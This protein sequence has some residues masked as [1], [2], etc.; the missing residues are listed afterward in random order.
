M[1]S[2]WGLDLSNLILQTRNKD[3]VKSISNSQKYFWFKVKLDDTRYS[4][5]LGDQGRSD[6]WAW[7]VRD[8]DGKQV[9]HNVDIK[10]DYRSTIQPLQ[11]GVED[12]KPWLLFSDSRNRRIEIRFN[13]IDNSDPM[14]TL[15]EVTPVKIK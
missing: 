4:Y 13:S 1:T 5:L 6:P 12:T 15:D 7:C 14:P 3:S 9:P 8:P 2:V 10:R 11:K